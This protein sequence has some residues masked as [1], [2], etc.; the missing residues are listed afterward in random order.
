MKK[1]LTIIF[2]ILLCTGTLAIGEEDDT[3]RTAPIITNAYELSSGKLYLEWEG[4]APVYQVYM[5]GKSVTDVIV[6][7]AVIDI[8]KGTHTILVYPINEAKSADTKINI[9]SDNALI[10]GNLEVDLAILGLDPK[11]LTAGSPSAALNI[12]YTPNPI[13]NA[14]PD[15]LTATTDFDNVVQLSFVDRY[16]SDE[17]VVTIKVG[18]DTS[19]VKFST[20]DEKTAP[21][22]N[23]NNDLVTLTLDPDYL[24]SQECM[25]PELDKEYK[26]SVQL[27]KYAQNYVNGESVTAA[28]HASKDSSN[29]PYTPVAAWKTAPVLSYAS[30]TADGQLTLQWTHNDNSLGCE[31]VIMR[32]KKTLGIKTGEEEV[33]VVTGTTFVLNDLMNGKYCYTVVP[34][35]NNEI[36]AASEEVNIEITNDWVVAPILSCEQVGDTSIKLT[37]TAAANVDTYHITIYTGDS[38]SI[39]RFVNLDFSKFS[40]HDLPATSGEMEF[41]FSY[42]NEIDPENGQKVK[43]EVYGIRYAANGDE[44][45]TATTK[46]VFT[47]TVPNTPAE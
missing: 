3:W 8:T 19:Y 28:V 45:T 23:K 30:Q 41:V 35:L 34:R 11:N 47:I 25:I 14:A 43:F 15:E 10:G 46:Q 31:Y 22:I 13:L 12:D 5:D 9:G 18:K 37:W 27:R 20:S 2:V 4:Y 40:E 29:Y 21:L 1:L 24:R 7:N 16:Y 26:F 39:L 17:Y 42:P 6:S 33:G 44:Q 38:K 32:V 36:G